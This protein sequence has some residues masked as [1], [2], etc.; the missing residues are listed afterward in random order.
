MPFSGKDTMKGLTKEK[1][2]HLV[3]VALV[4]V[5]A[6]GG[7]AYGLI[8]PQYQNW[9]SLKGKKEA[10]KRQLQQV[11]QTIE[12][13]EQIDSSLC[14]AKRQLDKVEEGM[15]SGDLYSWAI[16]TIR[17][18]KLP[19]KVEIP[20]YSQIDGPRDTTLLPT[21]PYKQATITIGGNAQFTEFGRF[22]ADLENQFPYFRLLNVS[23]EPV[24]AASGA[25]RERL[26]FKMEIA[27]LVKPGAS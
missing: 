2:Q 5:M 10:A 25:D 7:L 6:L 11:M 15:P 27:M 8:R 17:T 22:V 4:T 19:Y 12:N 20:Q 3:L 1:Q 14:E 24:S 21:F 9:Q 23:L 18:F 16:T 26:A 13:A